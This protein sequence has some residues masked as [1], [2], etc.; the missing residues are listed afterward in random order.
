MRL[1]SIIIIAALLF[2]ISAPPSLAITTSGNNSLTIIDGDS[3][4]Q[5]LTFINRISESKETPFSVYADDGTILQPNV[6]LHQG[7][8]FNFTITAGGSIIPG[9]VDFVIT[10][11]VSAILYTSIGD[12]V[13]THSQGYIPLIGDNKRRIEI[14]YAINLTTKEHYLVVLDDSN[15]GCG[16]PVNDLHGSGITSF[17]TSNPVGELEYDVYV[18]S[19][20][21]YSGAVNSGEDF[22]NGSNNLLDY[23]GRSVDLIF[24][25]FGALVTVILILKVILIDNFFLTLGLAEGGIL[26]LSLRQNKND[27]FGFANDWV[28]Y[29]VRFIT[30]MVNAFISFINGFMMLAQ[31]GYN[32]LKSVPII[33][34]FL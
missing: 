14:G 7:E 4:P 11:P 10:S 19:I 32:L 21:D 2:L 18:Y 24:S 28:Q 17:S 8:S 23:V 27:I 9:Y 34:Q 3:Q 15:Y 30:F 6:Y 1:T 31:I 22:A 13:Q 5:D 25:I 26:I 29:N 16:I 12:E 20:D 33:G